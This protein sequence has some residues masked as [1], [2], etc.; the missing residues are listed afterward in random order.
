MDI[1]A[2]RLEHDDLA[3]V[4]YARGGLLVVVGPEINL[5]MLSWA[6]CSRTVS[7]SVIV[8]SDANQS[9][10]VKRIVVRDSQHARITIGS[11]HFPEKSCRAR[12]LCGARASARANGAYMWTSHR[13]V[14]LCCATPRYVDV[15]CRVLLLA[16]FFLVFVFGTAATGFVDGPSA[17]AVDTVAPFAAISIKTRRCCPIPCPPDPSNSTKFTPPNSPTDSTRGPRGQRTV[18]WR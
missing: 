13:R 16:G 18:I 15:F 17:E 2:R 1:I 14:I 8:I 6:V 5:F 4:E 3:P 9:M 10:R 12:E 11:W 7:P